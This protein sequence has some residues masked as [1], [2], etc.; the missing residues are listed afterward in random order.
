MQNILK[1]RVWNGKLDRA[2]TVETLAGATV[3]QN[4]ISELTSQFMSVAKCLV[5]VNALDFA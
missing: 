2:I 5:T 3:M 4:I 1:S